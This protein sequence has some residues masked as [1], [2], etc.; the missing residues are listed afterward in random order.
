MNPLAMVRN[1][2]GFM[3]WFWEQVY[4]ELDAYADEL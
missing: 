1:F 2:A 4:M 3:M